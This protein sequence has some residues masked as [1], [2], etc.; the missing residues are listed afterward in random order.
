MKVS[1][2]S[3]TKN[4]EKVIATAARVC[5]SGLP[6]NKLLTKYSEEENRDLVKRVVEMGHLSVVEHAVFTFK[7]SPDF[8][9][10]LFEIMID[11]PFLKISNCEDYFIVSLNLRTMIE[12]SREKPELCLVREISKYIPEFLRQTG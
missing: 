6:L 8:K 10:E 12:L 11:K 7:V 2:I 4:Y 9:G 1:L 3:V 5:Y